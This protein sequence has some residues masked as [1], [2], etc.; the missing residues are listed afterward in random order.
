MLLTGCPV[1]T[2]QRSSYGHPCRLGNRAISPASGGTCGQSGRGRFGPRRD[3]C[4]Y[5]RPLPVGY[6][7]SGDCPL[8]WR[9]RPCADPT[10]E[11]HDDPGRAPRGRRSA[12]RL[13]DPDHQRLAIV[14]PR[15]P[16]RGAR[17]G[18]PTGHDAGDD[19][20]AGPPPT[21]SRERGGLS[22]CTVPKHALETPSRRS[23]ITGG[24]RVGRGTACR[25]LLIGTNAA[26]GKRTRHAV[27]LQMDR[28]SNVHRR[29]T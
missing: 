20:R 6:G 21:R 2:M 7:R 10:R 25:A 24:A 3:L 11:D 14:L 19:R 16:P 26:F 8:P 23:G 4:P 27:P 28:H 22:S 18:R 29:P 1:I 17:Y 15:N 13:V 9:K 5:P 12:R